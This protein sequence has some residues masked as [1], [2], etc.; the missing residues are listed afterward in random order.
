MLAAYA[1]QVICE[2]R[3]LTLLVKKNIKDRNLRLGDSCAS[4]VGGFLCNF[5]TS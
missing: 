3:P 4:T 5:C 2:G 1:M